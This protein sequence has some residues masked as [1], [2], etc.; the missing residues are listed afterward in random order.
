MASPYVKR[1]AT[2]TPQTQPIAGRESE[3]VANN[4]GGF[5]FKLNDWERLYRFLIL[6]SEGGTY[7][8]GEQKLTEQNAAC[9]IRCIKEDGLKAVGWAEDINVNNRA[10]KTDQQLFVLALALKYGNNATK[11]RVR[12]VAPGMLRTGTHL[13]HFVAMVDSLGGW[14]RAKANIVRDWFEHHPSDWLA[15]QII[16]YRS[17]DGWSMRDALRVAHPKALTSKHAWL[18]DYTCG[19][20]STEADWPDLI[21][22]NEIM[23]ATALEEDAVKGALFGLAHGL[24]REALPT[25]ALKDPKVWEALLPAMAPHQLLRNLGNLAARGLLDQRNE[26]VIEKLC[27]QKTLSK[28]RVH[29]F[30][31]LLAQLVYM[32]G[33]GVRGGNKWSLDRWV[34]EALDDAYDLSFSAAAPTGK[35]LLV[36]IDVSA[37]MRQDCVGTP[38]SAETAAAAMALTIARLEPYATVVQF[39]TAVRRV[40]PVTKRSSLSSLPVTSRGGGTDLSA[41]LRWAMGDGVDALAGY[42]QK[43]GSA[44]AARVE[45]YDAFILLTDNETWAGR[46][47]TSQVLSDYRRKVNPQARLICCAMAANHANIVDPEDKLSLGCAGLDTNIPSI[48]TEFING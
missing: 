10:P 5:G 1:R 43:Q 14:G 12:N 48:V 13:L 6:G 19:R 28:A 35:R 32:Q 15:Y 30:A 36:A 29:P 46:A 3:M 34:V 18:Y 44:G 42:F 20:K 24:P 9:A 7:Y 39:D 26:T 45:H 41:P 22:D 33:H 4:A 8:V 25:E 17:R 38:I 2:A 40:L 27:N 37:S 31:I 47:H 23:R 11:L 16:K 21:V